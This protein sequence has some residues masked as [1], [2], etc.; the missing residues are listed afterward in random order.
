MV[1]PNYSPQ[2]SASHAHARP[3]RLLPPPLFTTCSSRFQ[4]PHTSPLSVSSSSKSRRSPSSATSSPT[5]SPSSSS[6]HPPSPASPPSRLSPPNATPFPRLLISCGNNPVQI[7]S[8]GSP[9]SHPSSPPFPACPILKPRFRP[10]PSPDAAR[11]LSEEAF[12]REGGD[13]TPMSPSSTGFVASGTHRRTGGRKRHK[14]GICVPR[15]R[16]ETRRDM[17][18]RKARK[19]GDENGSNSCDF[20]VQ[21]SV[22]SN[23]NSVHTSQHLP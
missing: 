10:L 21:R 5:S 4:A 12:L 1:M 6:R 16:Q 8:V 19:I 9:S 18:R 14:R 20:V 2:L 15:E 11:P 23:G 22:R 7:K 13:K 3:Q 17:E